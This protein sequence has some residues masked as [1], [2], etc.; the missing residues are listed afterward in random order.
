MKKGK[1]KKQHSRAFDITISDETFER[2]LA[3]HYD[4]LK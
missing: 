4:E 1:S 2:R 3:R